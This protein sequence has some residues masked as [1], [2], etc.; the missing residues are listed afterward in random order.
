[1]A[2]PSLA[3]FIFNNNNNNIKKNQK[4]FKDHFKIFV[5]FSHIFPTILHNNIDLVLK[6]LVFSENFQKILKIQKKI[7]LISS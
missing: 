1:M 3:Q 6:Y 7:K 5:I 4:Q 2:E